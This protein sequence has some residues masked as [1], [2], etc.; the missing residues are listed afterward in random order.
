MP[1]KNGKR[2][3]MWQYPTFFLVRQK[4]NDTIEHFTF[5]Y[6]QPQFLAKKKNKFLF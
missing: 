5:S 1:G 3:N 2:L 6:A 4:G